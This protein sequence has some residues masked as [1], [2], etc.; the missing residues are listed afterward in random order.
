MMNRFLMTATKAYKS[1]SYLYLVILVYGILISMVS[2]APQEA[3]VNQRKIEREREKKHK[4]AV[5]EYNDAVKRHNKM[6][7]KSTRDSM[8]KT[9]KESKNVTPV[10]R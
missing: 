8:R 5:R 9:K 6:Q 2:C 3:R 4:Q 10:K 1:I 7:S